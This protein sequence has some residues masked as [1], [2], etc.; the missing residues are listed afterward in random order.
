MKKTIVDNRTG[1]KKI[2]ND[3]SI[4]VA[5][6]NGTGSQ[7]SNLSLLKA[8]F[9]MGLPVNGKNIF[10]SNIQGLPTWYHIRV[11]FENYVAFRGQ[12]EILVAFN[13]STIKDDIALLP[14]GGVCIYPTDGRDIDL[15]EDVYNYGLPVRHFLNETGTSGRLKDY[16]VNMVYVGALAKLL[17]IDL[18]LIGQAL[19]HHFGGRQNLIDPNMAVI[20]VAY[21]WVEQNIEKEDP[22]SV[23]PLD[24]TA[25]QVLI[26]GNEAAA[27]GAVYGGVTL[28]AWYP[29]TPSTSLIDALNDFLPRLRTDPETGLATYVTIQAED[30]LA[31]AGM[32]MGAGW[33]G[34]RAMTATSGP[35][36]SLMSEFV[37]LGYFSEIPAVIWNIQRVGPSTGL[38]TRTSQGDVL[39]AYYLGHGDTK[40]I[41][42]FPATVKECFEFGVLAFDLAEELQTPIIVMSDLDLGMNTWMTPQFE[43]P[44]EPLKRGKI[45]TAEDVEAQGFYRYVDVDGDGITYRTLP[46]NEH[47]KAAYFNRGT[48]HN[49]YGVYS[50]KSADWEENMERLK[51][52]FRTA[53]TLLPAPIWETEAS[54]KIGIISYGSTLPAIEEA[55][56]RLQ[57]RGLHTNALRLRALPINDEVHQFI[58]VHERSY[59]V[60]LNRD[61]QMHQILTTENPDMASGLISLAHLDGLPLTADWLVNQLLEKEQVLSSARSDLNGNS[62]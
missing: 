6:V 18:D 41:L 40:N 8:M 60:E 2:L 16:I 10:P 11:S 30:E 29:I 3:F 14:A 38:P 7:T 1:L 5:T 15:R 27:L 58:K 59:V 33:A 31:A 46:G 48:G 54:I 56:S 36:I 51:R 49:R 43:Y 55:R 47:P 42:L 28:T 21:E 35:G 22:Y 44:E 53:R 17:N 39:F 9:K 57:S 25:G 32:I 34:A 26:T 20:N 52:K 24:L 61:G 45:L 37:G 19:I 12:S 62:N 13:Q 4:V 50:E 23:E